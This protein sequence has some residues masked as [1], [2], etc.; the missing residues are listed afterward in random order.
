MLVLILF[1]VALAYSSQEA[2]LE[3][4]RACNP[5]EPV[6]EYKGCLK[7]CQLIHGKD[8]EQVNMLMQRRYDEL[9]RDD[10]MKKFTT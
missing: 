5:H 1:F 7:T 10:K 3:C 9:V 8:A 2:Y 4:V 6:H